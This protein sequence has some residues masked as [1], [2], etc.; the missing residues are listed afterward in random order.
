MSNILKILI[1]YIN[2]WQNQSILRFLSELLTRESANSLTVVNNCSKISFATNSKNIPNINIFS[3]FD[4]DLY[5]SILKYESL[6]INFYNK[7]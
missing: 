7:I 5:H 3:C 2:F 4:L 6:K 1:L